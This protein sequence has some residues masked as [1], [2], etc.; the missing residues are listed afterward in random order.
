MLSI[1]YEQPLC[2]F[3]Q[4]K[5]QSVYTEIQPPPNHQVY[6]QQIFCQTTCLDFC[7]C[8][9]YNGNRT[10]KR[11]MVLCPYV[12]YLLCRCHTAQTTSHAITFPIPRKLSKISSS[13]ISWKYN[14]NIIVPCSYT[15]KTD[16]R[17]NCC[18]AY[19]STSTTSA[20]FHSGSYT[21][22]YTHYM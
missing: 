15:T 6:G 18:T 2:S 10:L 20:E 21:V 22:Y 14:T 12:Q 8:T 11:W 16:S 13:F 1:A 17:F 9:F 3:C 7:N 19:N 5:R 4:L